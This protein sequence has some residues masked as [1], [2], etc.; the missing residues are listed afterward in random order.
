[1]SYLNSSQAQE[2]DVFA[3]PNSDKELAEKIEALTSHSTAGLEERRGSRGGSLLDAEDRFQGVP[4]AVLN[5]SGDAVLGC[6]TSLAEANSF[7]GR[8]LKTGERILGTDPAEKRTAKQAAEYGMEVEEYR[9][10]MELIEKAALQRSQTTNAATLTIVNGDGAGEGF[11]DP[12]VV[13]PEGGNT[14][15]TRGEQRLNVFN[16]AAQIWGAFLD[17]NVPTQ[18]F[19]KF[20][21]LT[22]CSSSGGV[23][24]QAG[25]VTFVRNIPN[26]T[27]NTYYPISLANKTAGADLNGSSNEINATFNSE[28]DNGCLGGGSR[29]YYGLNN[30]TPGGRINLLVVLLH[31]MG[32]GLGFQSLANAQTGALANGSPDTYTRNMYDA[33][34]NMSWVDMTNAQ[35][36]TSATNTG[37]LYWDGPSVRGASAALNAP[38]CRDAAT[39]RLQLFAPNPFQSGSSV[40]HWNTT[41]SPNL[42]MEPNIT[43]GLPLTLDMTRQVM[44]DIGWYR[45]TNGDLTPDSITNVTP[46]GI[47]VLAG[48]AADVM[49]TNGGGFSQNVAID[50]SLDGGTTFTNVASNVPNTGAYTLALP[51]TTSLTARI[52]VR[53]DGFTAPAGTSA[54]S[55]AI[56]TGLP[57][58]TPTPAAT[59]TPTPTPTPSPSPTPPV[60]PT[61]SPTRTPTPSP[62]PEFDLS[63]TQSDSPDP[64]TVSGTLTYTLTVT[65]TPA[66]LGGSASPQVRFN[67][68]T[69]I[70]ATPVSA[71]GSNGYVATTDASGITFSGG[72]LSTSGLSAGTATLLVVVRPLASGTLTSAGA[73]VIVDPNNL[74]NEASETNNTASTITTV[75]NAAMTP[76]PTPAP[77]P[78]FFSLEGRVFT[79]GSVGIRSAVVV[80]TDSAGNRRTST[81]S[82][83]GVYSFQN[84]DAGQSYTLTVASKRYRFAPRTVAMTSSLTNMDFF[85][86]E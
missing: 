60:T 27:P 32:H 25:A 56:V 5:E 26:G 44:R 50:L 77:G 64:A 53:E 41:C 31:E 39:G 8:D 71:T 13:I 20:D 33:S 3:N 11:N 83:F 9:F 29:F 73:N 74:V 84:L 7:F 34:T 86:L 72:V 19:S 38:A 47:S 69:G 80:L 57:S 2:R 63:I 59:P 46:A 81:T 82:S 21:P 78:T 10:Y 70:P 79:P 37:S 55:F 40:A 42:L 24:G 52:R 48:E 49:W 61:P 22:P 16:F 62:V 6:A 75:V 66:A 17:S 43:V 36:V 67:F 30:T 85:G 76:T 1:L 28:V 15:L 68:P 65:I 54:A 45:D 58:P 4:L 14:G 35:R 23:L 12:A 51:N 18:I